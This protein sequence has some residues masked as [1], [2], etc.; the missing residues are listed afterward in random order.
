MSGAVAAILS[1]C[2]RT[3]RHSTRSTSP[4]GRCF[5]RSLF[6]PIRCSVSTG[7]LHSSV[8]PIEP[9]TRRFGRWKLRFSAAS[10]L[11]GSFSTGPSMDRHR[12]TN[13]VRSV[14]AIKDRSR[15]GTAVRVAASSQ[16]GRSR[17]RERHDDQLTLVAACRDSLRVIRGQRGIDYE[18]DLEPVIQEAEDLSQWLEEVWTDGLQAYREM[19]RDYRTIVHKEKYVSPDG[20]HTNQ[21]KCLFSL[22]QP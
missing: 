22:V 3:E 16:S 7:S 1:R 18:G 5:S 6:T 21:A 13:L 19:D 9:F 11:S 20:V 8:E 2:T 14:R 4:Q 15:R 12:S 10:P 17:W